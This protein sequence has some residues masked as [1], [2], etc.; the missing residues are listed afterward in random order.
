MSADLMMDLL[1]KYNLLSKLLEKETSPIKRVKYEG[2]LE[3]ISYILEN[4]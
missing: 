1:Y 4:Y 2:M 3:A